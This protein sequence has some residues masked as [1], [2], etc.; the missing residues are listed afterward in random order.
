MDLADAVEAV[1][2]GLTVRLSGE[3][4]NH[5][6]GVPEHRVATL[7]PAEGLTRGQRVLVHMWHEDAYVASVVRKV[8][9]GRVQVAFPWGAEVWLTEPS[10]VVARLTFED[11]GAG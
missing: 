3:G 9:R 5:R 1:A 6:F 8:S 11:A 10:R 7:S 4:Y 2:K